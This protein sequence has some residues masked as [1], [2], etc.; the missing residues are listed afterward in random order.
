M[1]H[2]GQASGTKKLNKVRRQGVYQNY[3]RAK[4]LQ[5]A[6]NM[7]GSPTILPSSNPLR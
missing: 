1:R 7:S 4:I 5:A 2:E 6:F 3:D